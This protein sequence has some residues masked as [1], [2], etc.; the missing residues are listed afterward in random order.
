MDKSFW[1]FSGLDSYTCMLHVAPIFIKNV[2]KVPT[3]KKG[4]FKLQNSNFLYFSD[5]LP[6]KV[7]VITGI[8]LPTATALVVT[9]LGNDQIIH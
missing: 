4:N 6:T 3:Q 5:S 1:D 2:I 9:Q 7:L 8:K